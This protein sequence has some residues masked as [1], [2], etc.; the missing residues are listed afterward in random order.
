MR[1]FNSAIDTLNTNLDEF[2]YIYEETK[3]LKAE[4]FH[5]LKPIYFYVLISIILVFYNIAYVLLAMRQIGFRRNDTGILSV[6]IVSETRTII[7]PWRRGESI[8]YKYTLRNYTSGI[9]MFCLHQVY[10]FQELRRCD[11]SLHEF[12]YLLTEQLKRCQLFHWCVAAQHV[13]NKT[14]NISYEGFFF[15]NWLIIAADKAIIYPRIATNVFNLKSGLSSLTQKVK[16]THASQIVASINGESL[17]L[18][19]VNLELLCQKLFGQRFRTTDIYL[20][21]ARVVL[22]SSAVEITAMKLILGERRDIVL[23]VHPD[24]NPRMV[25]LLKRKGYKLSNL[26]L[27]IGNEVTFIGWSSTALIELANAGEIVLVITTD[28]WE[29]VFQNR[30]WSGVNDRN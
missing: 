11:V 13:K 4:E 20:P 25:S 23:C 18:R 9:K 15:E 7:L 3:H 8:N 26:K 29:N 6:N 14:I 28:G 16:H 5:A 12:L 24:T 10:Y 2:I 19:E 21:N 27:E 1:H 17:D 22:S 30:Y